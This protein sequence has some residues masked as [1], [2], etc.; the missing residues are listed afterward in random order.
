MND[1]LEDISEA[2]QPAPYK[3]RA[4]HRE[5]KIPNR[6]P[7]Y[8]SMLILLAALSTVAGYRVARLKITGPSWFGSSLPLA[9]AAV[10]APAL[11]PASHPRAN[12]GD[13]EAITPLPP[14]KQA[15]RLLEFAVRRPDQSLGLIHKNLD[16]WRGHLEETD[17]LFQMAA[18]GIQILVD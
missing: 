12:N 4:A 3:L 2:P 18:P 17:Q 5:S 16:S 7:L 11:V 6:L 13:M 9:A 10:Q 8:V 1:S 15:E 14:Q